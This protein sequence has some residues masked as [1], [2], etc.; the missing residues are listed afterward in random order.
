MNDLQ[1]CDVHSP[2]LGVCV[3]VRNI[4]NHARGPLQS[5]RHP[6][7]LLWYVQCLH[8]HCLFLDM[9]SDFLRQVDE[10]CAILGYYAAYSDDSLPMFPDP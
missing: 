10:I 8:R 6:T 3:A 5:Y 1:L 9:S 4:L 2:P 7:T